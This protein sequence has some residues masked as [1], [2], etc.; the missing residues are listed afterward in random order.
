MFTNKFKATEKGSEERKKIFKDTLFGLGNA[1][2]FTSEVGEDSDKVYIE[3]KKYI[4]VRNTNK[5]Y[6]TQ[7][8]VSITRDGK[9][10]E[11]AS[12]TAEG[13]LVPRGTY[14]VYEVVD[15]V[16]TPNSTGVADLSARPTKDQ[17]IRAVNAKIARRETIKPQLTP[18]QT[19]TSITPGVP[20]APQ[21]S[22][23]TQGDK[24]TGGI[25]GGL[26]QLPSSGEDFNNMPL[27]FFTD[28]QVDQNPC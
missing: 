9:T 8:L 1:G 17:V 14:G 28:D 12:M 27:D 10:Y 11:G 13:E 3:F 18:Q 2:F 16:G 25:F 20:T 24:I 21:P 4:R 6:S 15:A 19:Q 7:K 26:Q 22:E 23:S 5:T